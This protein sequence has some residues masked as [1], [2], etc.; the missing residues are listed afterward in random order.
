MK[1]ILALSFAALISATLNASAQ[2]N[3]KVFQNDPNMQIISVSEIA[4]L[5]D[6]TYVTLKGNITGK[7]GNE[8]Y[9]FTDN[10]GTIA[11]E[12]DGDTWEG[13]NVTPD[14]IVIIEGEIDKNIN[15]P[16]IIEVDTI[17]LDQ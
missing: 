6:E 10:S 16:T 11:L 1:K 13:I 14:S 9:I 5:P 17:S 15:E 12:I 7:S 2:N 8:M 4:N 3:N